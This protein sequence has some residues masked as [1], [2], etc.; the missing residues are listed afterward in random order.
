MTF[1]YFCDIVFPSSKSFQKQK[2]SDQKRRFDGNFLC[3]IKLDREIIAFL[4]ESGFSLRV[5]T[6]I[7]LNHKFNYLLLHFKMFIL[8][9]LFSFFLFL[10]PPLLIHNYSKIHIITILLSRRE[11]LSKSITNKYENSGAAVCYGNSLIVHEHQILSAQC[12]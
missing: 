2:K 11:W 12:D 3:V 10:I 7:K 6:T 9:L 8:F 5:F 4:F 1:N